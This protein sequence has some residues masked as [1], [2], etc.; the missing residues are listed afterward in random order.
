MRFESTFPLLIS[1]NER[2]YYISSLKD[3]SGLVRSYALVDAEDY[4]RVITSDTV[5]GLIAQLNGR[6]V[7]DGEEEELEEII[8]VDDENLTT[9]Q[10][11][12]DNI[13]QA[14]VSGN[15]IYYFMIDG[16]I[17]KADVTLDDALPFVE[18]GQVIEGEANDNNEFKLIILD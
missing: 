9:V 15:T 10:G 2:P 14:V 13:S 4:Q 18:E 11:E 7:S 17:Y 3:D 6:S 5:D 12:V 1:L 8:E 16:T